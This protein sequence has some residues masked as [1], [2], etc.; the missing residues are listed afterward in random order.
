VFQGHYS[1]TVDEVIED[2]V[3]KLI[4]GVWRKI[5]ISNSAQPRT[6]TDGYVGKVG[7]CF[8]MV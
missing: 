3:G 4:M 5:N 1:D 8:E 7:T 6:T 2:S